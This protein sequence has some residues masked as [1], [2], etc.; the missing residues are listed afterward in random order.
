MKVRDIMVAYQVEKF[1]QDSS[2][3]YRGRYHQ[4]AEAIVKDCWSLD[5]AW[6]LSHPDFYEQIR[7]LDDQLTTMERLG[8]SEE[9]YDATLA[10]LVRCINEARVAYEQ[11]REQARAPEAQ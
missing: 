10:R 5:P 3:D 4:T 9:E 1:L 2:P 7:A 8:V 6:L 11:E